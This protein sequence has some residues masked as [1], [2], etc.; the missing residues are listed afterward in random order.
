MR[1]ASAPCAHFP[2]L[3]LIMILLRTQDKLLQPMTWG[4]PTIYTIQWD[5]QNSG[6]QDDC[7]TPVC[8]KYWVT[9]KGWDSK[10]DLK[11][12]MY[13]DPRL[14]LVFCLLKIIILP[15]KSKKLTVAGNHDYTKTDRVNSVQSSLTS[16][17]LWV[18]L[19]SNEHKTQQFF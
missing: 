19:K 7:W 2:A 14:N 11:L 10:D 12:L 3:F 1:L 9:H 18:T 6:I 8:F 15:K 4:N 5:P 17:P 16:H 13:V